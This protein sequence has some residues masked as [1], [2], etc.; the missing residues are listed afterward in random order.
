MRLRCCCFCLAWIVFVPVLAL[1]QEDSE[2]GVPLRKAIAAYEQGKYD[3]AI[4]RYTEG[5]ALA[6]RARGAAHEGKGDHDKA[7]RD[8]AES[9]RLN[10]KDPITY[11]NRAIAYEKKGSTE[12]AIA[13]YSEA[14]RLERQFVPA[15]VNR[16]INYQRVAN[17]E[18]AATDYN[19]AIRIGPDSWVPCE[20]LAWLLATC[21][22]DTVRDGKRAVELARKACQ[23]DSWNNPWRLDTLAAAYAEHGSFKDATKWAKVAIEQAKDAPKQKIE[24]MK[25]RLKLYEAGKPYRETPKTADPPLEQPHEKNGHGLASILASLGYEQVP[26]QDEMGYL[27][28]ATT[29]NG[30][31]R[32]FVL[33]SGSPVTSLDWATADR[34]KLQI[35]NERKEVVPFGG[36]VRGGWT[37]LDSLQVGRVTITGMRGIFVTDL[38][39][40]NNSDAKRVGARNVDGLLGGDTLARFSAVIDFHSHQLFLLPPEKHKRMF[41]GNWRCQCYETNGDSTAKATDISL[42]TGAKSLS[43]TSEHRKMEGDFTLDMDLQPIGIELTSV[44]ANGEKQVRHG[45]TRF[46]AEQLVLCL[47]P[48]GSRQNPKSFSTAKTGCETWVFK[49]SQMPPDRSKLASGARHRIIRSMPI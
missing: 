32:S 43:L 48:P 2:T 7:L 17:Y 49:R 39:Y 15:Y 18:K 9:I 23:L 8:Y 42:T 37:H 35:A 11:Y 40:V 46:D 19:E 44:S 27:F 3:E 36:R 16:A 45:I 34:S 12:K 47:A 31:K 38:T 1:A 26:L 20:G 28:V 6:F 13:D 22:K 5:I 41:E 24:E 29:V 10:P 4:A 33:D 21:P 25:A 30:T 14:I